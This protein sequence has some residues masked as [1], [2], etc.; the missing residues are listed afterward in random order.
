VRH[1]HFTPF[2]IN[3]YGT[4]LTFGELCKERTQL[5]GILI[6]CRVDILHTCNVFSWKRAVKQSNLTESSRT[7][8]WNATTPQ[9]CQ[10]KFYIIHHSCKH[11][12]IHCIIGAFILL[13][14][15]FFVRAGYILN[16]NVVRTQKDK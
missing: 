12:C 4:V 7:A 13:Y 8:A 11:T 3:G 6:V 14:V 2:L 1:H 15:Y 5:T 16:V 10:G 9:H